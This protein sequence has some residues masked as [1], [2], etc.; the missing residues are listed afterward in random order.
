MVPSGSK[1]TASLTQ[2]PSKPR[3]LILTDITNEPDD[4]ES[5]CRYLTYA[6]QFR[7]EGIVAVTPTWLRNKVAPQNLHEIVDAHEKVVDNLKAHTHPSSPYPLGAERARPHQVYGMAAVGDGIPLSEGAELLLE[8][9][10]AREEDP[11]WVLVWGGVNVLAQVLDNIRNRPDAAKLCGKLRVYTISDQDDCGGWIRQQ[12]PDIFY[13]CSIHGWNQYQCAAW[14]GISSHYRSSGRC[15]PQFRVHHRGRHADFSARMQWTLS[16]DFGDVN[17]HPVASVN[18]DFGLTL[19][20]VEVDAGG[21]VSFDASES[22]DPDG[23]KLSFNWYQYRE[24]SSLQTYNGLEMSDIEIKPLK[25]DGSKAE[26][27]IAPAEKSCT[28]VRDKCSS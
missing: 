11:L 23:D 20:S 27:L 13:I 19:V 8:R 28:V 2:Y 6:N 17:H 22:Y 24:P 7:T 4:A 3:V 16:S 12:W 5:F 25:D 15:I 1:G 9:L 21:V 14:T 10:T 18:G 26:V